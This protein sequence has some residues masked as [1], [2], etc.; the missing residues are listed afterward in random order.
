MHVLILGDTLR[1]PSSAA[2]A[3]QLSKRGVSFSCLDTAAL[4]TLHHLSDDVSGTVESITDLPNVDSP[5][6]VWFRRISPPQVAN[7]IEDAEERFFAEETWLYGLI[8]TLSGCPIWVNPFW[9]HRAANNKLAQLRLARRNGLAIPRTLV[10]SSPERA[11]EFLSQGDQFICKAAHNHFRGFSTATVLLSPDKIAKLD[12]LPTCPAIF[13]QRIR[14]KKNIRVVFC[15]RTV[16]SFEAD[17]CGIDWRLQPNNAWRLHS[18]PSAID[19]SLRMLLRD[20]GL[21]YG[22]IDLI[23][24]QDSGYVFLELN[25][26][27]Q[28]MFLELWTEAGI[29]AAIAEMLIEAARSPLK[30][31]AAETRS[32]SQLDDSGEFGCDSF[33]EAVADR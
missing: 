22:V 17:D 23:Q 20:L 30:T 33:P 10:T 32:A 1:D 19:A 11:K 18:L 14:V 26:G 5:S 25:P 24:D 15:G 29:P 27:G 13:Q 4:G 9:Q 16:F 12:S 6:V 31:G 2:V 3:Q 21:V 28:F 7:A 8:G